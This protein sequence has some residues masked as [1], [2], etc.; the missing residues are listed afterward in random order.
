MLSLLSVALLSGRRASVCKP[1]PP[2][3]ADNYEAMVG[4]T[5]SPLSFRSL[6]NHPYRLSCQYQ[7]FLRL[8][9]LKEI[10][11]SLKDNQSP[12]PLE[13][14]PVDVLHLLTFALSGVPTKLRR[15]SRRSEVH[16]S[17]H[18]VISSSDRLCL[19]VCGN[20]QCFPT[21]PKLMG[22]R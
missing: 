11:T 14:L 19:C 16:L 18:V 22:V 21:M 4:A 12:N 3:L 6:I 9:G 15:I 5:P 7:S 10:C 20:S 13:A 2:M 8:P 17:R 1:A